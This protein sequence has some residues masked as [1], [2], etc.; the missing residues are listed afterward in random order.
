[1]EDLT[2][3]SFGPYR[4]VG[5]LGEGG[6]A[7]VYKAYQPAIDRYVALK[8][9]PSHL[10]QDPEF[11]GRFRQEAKVLASL[12]HP[13]ILP[14]HDFGET[15][16]FTYIVMPFVRT[17]TLASVLRGQPLPLDR[18]QRVMSQI[19]DA[20]DC[21]H[22]QGLVH[23]DIKPSNIL[24]DD[25][26]NCLLADFGIAKI[27][28]GTQEFTRTGGIIGTP[29][30]MSPEQGLGNP[31]DARSDVYSLGV[32]LYEMATG[33]TP[34]K[35]ET[36]MATVL[37]HIKDPLPMPRSINPDLPEPVE[38]VILTAMHKQPGERFA[39]AGAMAA[40]LSSISA[41]APAP[42]PDEVATVLI[43]SPHPSDLATTIPASRPPT[44]PVEPTPAVSAEPSPAGPAADAAR[45]PA[46]AAGG[47]RSETGSS[48]SGGRWAAVLAIAAVAI[49]V[50]LL[51]R[52]TPSDET[53]DR[54]SNA[55]PAETAEVQPPAPADQIE[56]DAS[57]PGDD[58]ERAAAGLP[59]A[60]T[61]QL[62]ISV[63]AP[64]TV[65]IDGEAVGTFRPGEPQRVNVPSGQ[66]LIIATAEDG[67]TRRQVVVEVASAGSEV[68]VVELAAD[69]AERRD[70]EAAVVA[71]RDAETRR[72]EAV[73]VARERAEEER[74]LFEE[75]L[76]ANDPFPYAND[77]TFLDRQTGVRWT[78]E[79]MPSQGVE[80]WLWTD[81]NA[82]CES[83]SLAGS[84]TWRLPLTDELDSLLRRVEP[85][86]YGWGCC[87]VWSSSRPFGVADRLWVTLPT[88]LFA[89]PEWSS[90]VRDVSARRLTHRA[91][92]VDAPPR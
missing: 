12:Q 23:R 18:I 42:A 92:C 81:A 90:E 34:F 84:S 89:V 74:R 60:V 72:T 33:R 28:E 75:A 9:L 64:S 51:L 16:G 79:S 62:L 49:I 26:G 25:R 39:S 37:K 1:M 36:P 40:A 82:Y 70:R 48:R 55:P 59:A 15:D 78:A 68:V 85:G 27:L 66:H 61:G 41:D 91:V 31:L 88:S 10:A 5:P 20:L 63:D 21:A 43:G 52:D 67:E 50:L 45:E 47:D 29:A 65:T 13:H 80:G 54:A 83:L 30:Y 35:A 19:G 8:I 3:R 14:V 32:V 11:L 38:R 71:R 58:R 87:S 56:S 86:R 6:M 57:E 53:A 77:G 4:I 22:A 24:M 73:A 44:A 17:G 69:I 2:G 76:T 7:S 46:V